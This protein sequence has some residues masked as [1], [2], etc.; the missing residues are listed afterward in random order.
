MVALLAAIYWSTRLH[1]VL[2]FNTFSHV[3]L[4]KKYVQLINFH[5]L[6]LSQ[7]AQLLICERNL[8]CDYSLWW[9]IVFDYFH[10]Q[11][12]RSY[13][14]HLSCHRWICDQSLWSTKESCGRSL[15][16]VSYTWLDQAAPPQPGCEHQARLRRGVKPG[17][18]YETLSCLTFPLILDFFI[19]LLNNRP[20]V[21]NC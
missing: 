2:I 10:I 1:Y 21:K 11:S 13:T 7:S 20:K 14:L 19:L 3:A 16:W 15:T 8:S 6:P 18:T 9:I 5:C 12:V 17:L 4:V